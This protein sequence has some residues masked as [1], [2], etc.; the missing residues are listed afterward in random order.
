MDDIVK[1]M[2]ENKDYVIVDVRTPDEYKEGHIPN[3]INIPNETINET[4]YNKLKDKNQ[5]ILIYCRSGSRSRQAAYKMQKL[6]YTNLVDFG[7]IINWKGK[8]EK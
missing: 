7:G 1:I 2:D 5:L 6:G 4:V 8:I 3:A